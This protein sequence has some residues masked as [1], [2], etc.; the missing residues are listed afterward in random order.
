M[1]GRK[2]VVQLDYNGNIES[3]CDDINRVLGN[4][5]STDLV[6]VNLSSSWFPMRMIDMPQ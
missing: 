4:T 2:T 1:A 6:Y 5:P 3:L